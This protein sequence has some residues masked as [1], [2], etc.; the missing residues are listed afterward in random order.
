MEDYWALY[1][2]LEYLTVNV[3]YQKA[4]VSNVALSNNLNGKF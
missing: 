4:S 3:T 1:W 2:A